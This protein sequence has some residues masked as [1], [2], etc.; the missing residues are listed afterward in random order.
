LRRATRRLFLS[1]LGILAAAAVTGAWQVRGAQ[2]QSA[3][4]IEIEARRFEFSPNE[5]ALKA[6]EPVALL[7]RAIDFAHGFNLPDLHI[8][9][10]LVVGK[11]VKI[12]I[13]PKVAGAL[14]FH[15]DNFCGDDHEE[16][17]GRFMVTA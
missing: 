10:D 15:C 13:T 5:I 12:E 6:G 2:A 3:R 4:S 11:V 1:K 8:R 14:E 16:M 17:N 7:I 9:A